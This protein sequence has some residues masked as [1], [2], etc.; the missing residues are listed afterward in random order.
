MK[1]EMIQESKG[2]ESIQTMERFFALIDSGTLF[3]S[4]DSFFFK[5]LR[6]QVHSAIS[7]LLFWGRPFLEVSRGLNW[8]YEG[9]RKRYDIFRKIA[10]GEDK[11][12][13]RRQANLFLA[14]LPFPNQ[15]SWLFKVEKLYPDDGEVKAF[16]ADERKK[17]FERLQKKA[18]KIYKVRHFCQ[19][20]KAPGRENEKGVLRI[21]SIP[22]LFDSLAHLRQLSRR[23]ILIVEPPWGVVFRHSWLRKFSVLEEP[24][25]FGVNSNEDINFL[26]SQSHVVPF[27]LAHGDYMSESFEVKSSTVKEFDIVFNATFDEMKRKRH[28][29][30]LDLLNHHLLEDV[31]ALFLGRGQKAKVEHF[32]KQVRRAGLQ[33][34]VTVMANLLRENVP[35]QLGRCKMGVHL[36][37]NE[38][39]CRSIY[40]YFRSDLPCVV[41]SSMAGTNLGIFNP[42]TGMAVTDEELPEAISFALDHLDHFTPRRWFLES[43]GSSNSSRRLNQFLKQL[44]KKLGYQWRTNIVPL[45]SS[46]PGRYANPADY[47]L[48]RDEFGWIN[49]CLRSAGELP[50]KVVLD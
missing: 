28:K 44:F 17:G 47:E 4:E 29:L 11:T 12:H 10:E 18:Q 50:I 38:N 46:G 8:P 39:G 13:L 35:T 43:S 16:L 22:Y 5:K 15:W 25:V 19:V 24:S 31:R 2:N 6:Q 20:L 36:S 14:F 45:I 30:M 33:G 1:S 9:L 37:L 27:G 48:F 26:S 34:R 49:D 7:Y 42:Q 41:S 40:E 21:F 3:A 32:R 23:Y